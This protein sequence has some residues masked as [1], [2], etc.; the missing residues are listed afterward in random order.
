MKTYILAHDLGTGGN[1]A[2]IYD[3]D[4]KTI[5]SVFEEYESFHPQP[6]WAE[7]CPLDW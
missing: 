1:K 5:D 4:G 6:N 7:Q 3:Q 2:V